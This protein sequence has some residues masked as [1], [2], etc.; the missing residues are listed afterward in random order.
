MLGGDAGCPFI[1]ENRIFNEDVALHVDRETS[2][3][4]PY[5]NQMASAERREPS[6]CTRRNTVVAN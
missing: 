6:E 5:M 1:A 3:K 2:E 4:P